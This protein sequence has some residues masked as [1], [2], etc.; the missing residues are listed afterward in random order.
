M[1]ASNPNRSRG[2]PPGGRNVW[3]LVFVGVGLR[4]M[5]ELFRSVSGLWE[6]SYD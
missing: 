5:V 2:F 1:R 4:L 3:L 6:Y